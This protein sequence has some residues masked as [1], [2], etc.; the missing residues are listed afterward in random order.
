MGQVRTDVDHLRFH[1]AASKVYLDY[2]R[3]A[4]R[5][6]GVL[7]LALC[8]LASAPAGA[9]RGG[10]LEVRILF[11]FHGEDE[12]A[13]SNLIQSLSTQVNADGGDAAERYD[14]AHAQYR[15]GL[16]TAD[17]DP[18]RAQNAFEAC[19]TQLKPLLRA[20]PASVESLALQSACLSNLAPFKKYEAVLLRA[21]AADRL[22]TAVR[23]A[24]QNPRVAFLAALQ[25]LDR[26]P[27]GSADYARAFAR[28]ESAVRLF[29]RSSQTDVDSPSWGHAVA[30]LELG[31]QLIWQGDVVGARNWIEKA[32][33]V[34]PDFKA[35]R[36]QLAELL[37]R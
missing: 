17:R 37:N 31:R 15:L 27:H 4:A 29:E 23:L 28:L 14:L 36:R 21:R 32:L 5:S 10:D 2:M 8:G 1:G 11:A 12:S 24:P 19:D 30:Y 25:A 9:Q 20:D 7:L 13:L 34:A 6:I 3:A 35:A 16:L 22:A 26:S 18:R 33:L